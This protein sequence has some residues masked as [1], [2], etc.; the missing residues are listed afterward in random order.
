MRTPSALLAITIV[1]TLALTLGVTAATALANNGRAEVESVKSAESFATVRNELTPEELAAPQSA[2]ITLNLRNRDEL[3]ARV[4]KGD[5][6]S[7]QEMEEKYYPTHETWQSVAFWAQAQGLT[8]EDENSTHMSV[9]AH[10]QVAQI[11]AALNTRFARVLGDDG[12]EYTAAVTPASL[13]AELAPVVSGVLRLQPQIHPKAATTYP[14]IGVLTYGPQYLLDHYG[15]TSVG[16]GTGQTIAIFGFA[17]PPSPTDLT[18]YWAKIGS[19]HTLSDVTVINPSGFAPYNDDTSQ[20]LTDG[21]EVTMDTEIVTGL[22]PGAKV[23]VYCVTD[24]ASAAEAVIADLKNNPSIHQFTISAGDPEAN[25]P[26]TADS[27]YFM[28]LAAQGVTTF[29]ASGDGGSNPNP[30]TQYISYLDTATQTVEYPASD[31]YVTGVGGT[32]VVPILTDPSSTMSPSSGILA[33]LAW[34]SDTSPVFTLTSNITITFNGNGSNMSGG[35]VSSTFNRPS[36]QTGPGVPAG[37]MRT[38]PDVAA[39][40][41]G[42]NGGSPYIYDGAAD[43]GAGGTSAAAPI[44]AALCAI[45]NQNLQ[46]NGHNA[47]GLLNAKLYPL[48]GTNAMNY[49][50]QGEVTWQYSSEDTYFSIPASQYV[51]AGTVDTNGAYSVGPTYDCI[52]GIGT[53]NIANIAA[54]LEAPP[55]G[56]SVTVSTPLPSGPVVNGSAPITLQATATGSPTGYQWELNGVPIAG[57]TGATEIVYPTAANQGT[58]TVVVTNSAGSASTNAGTLTVTTDAWLVN[59]SARAYSQPGAN[60]LIAGFVTTGTSSKQLLI[61]GDGPILASFNLTGVLPDPTLTLTNTSTNPATTVAATNGWSTSMDSVF[62]QVGA[63]AFTPVGSHDT[64]LVETLAPGAYTAQVVSATTNSGVALAEVYDADDTAP[65]NRLVNISARVFVGTGG[66][67][68]IGGFVI[69]GNSP[70]TVVIRGDG[71]VLAGFN[72][73]GVLAQPTLTLYNTASPSPQIIATNTGWGNASVP[74]PGATSDIVVQPL[75]AAISA[76]VGAFA[77]PTG[78]ADSAMVVTLPPGGYTAEVTGAN[79][80]TGIALVEIYELR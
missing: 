57:A 68:L 72:L 71:P 78:S 65:T 11:A 32:Q 7:P 47:V 37:T 35:G 55:A 23:R 80:S 30:A 8:V 59:L 4:A 66:N 49:I 51:P 50:T 38:V 36:W 58:Y 10:G 14:S 17:A 42:T 9:K 27:Q 76:K 3:A 70:Q 39:V 53:P 54:A 79:N 77:L 46:A 41:A 18:T 16:D 43:G 28:A 64:A 40:A 6:I 34:T 5:V 25:S 33:E 22:C 73:S 2:M 52:T 19:S 1:Q 63:F 45:L 48:A 74:G 13:P 15:A 29:A 26:T 60:Q 44:W 61:R 56:L 67:I 12:K 75:T 24:I 20:G 21:Y 69:S 62:S 31:P